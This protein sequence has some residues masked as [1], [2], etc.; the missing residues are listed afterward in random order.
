[1]GRVA[2]DSNGNMTQDG[3]SAN[4]LVCDAENRLLSAIN[5]GSSGSYTYDGNNLRVTKSSGGTTTVYIFSGSKVIAEYDNGAAPASPSRE[6]VYAGSQLLAKIEAGATNYYHPD[7]LSARVTTDSSG[8]IAGQRG[9][10][11]FGDSWYSQSTTTKW[12]FTSYEHDSESG[13]D[14][15]MMRSYINRVGRF[16]SPDLFSGSRRNPQSLNRYSYVHNDPIN[17]TDPRGLRE[18]PLYACE[19]SA[20]TLTACSGNPFSGG[21]GGMSCA[22]QPG[23]SCV[24]MGLEIFDAIAGVA[25]TYQYQDMYGN[26]SFGFSQDLYQFV[27]SADGLSMS[28]WTYFVQN[29]GSDTIA[30]GFLANKI[31]SAEEAAWLNANFPGSTDE[32]TSRINAG[33]IGL[34]NSGANPA[35]IQLPIVIWNAVLSYVQ[36][37]GLG[38]DSFMYFYN[39]FMNLG[40]AFP[41]H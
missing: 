25:G 11:P 4:T 21:G 28:G 22:Y 41:P 36:Q 32:I 34:A 35:N 12:A 31:A 27:A 16:S 7:R 5:G 8:N 33:L 23:Q 38:D 14:Y 13:N 1:M 29:L 18:H 6:Y 30:S 3:P 40:P 19:T 24:V 2:Y 9:H 26:M 37:N 10:Y 17:S 39:Y 20:N 15:A